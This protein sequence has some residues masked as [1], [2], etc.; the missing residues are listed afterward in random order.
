MQAL[1]KVFVVSSSCKEFFHIKKSSQLDENAHSLYSGVTRFTVTPGCNSDVTR[2]YLGSTP[3]VP[4]VALQPGLHPG[5]TWV[6]PGLHPGYSVTRVTPGLHL[7]YTRVT[8]G[9]HLGDTRVAP[10]CHPGYTRSPGCNPG[11]TRV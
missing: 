9:L 3:G 2:V 11:V 10:G 8:P 4:R 5:Y 6:T 1:S 7:G